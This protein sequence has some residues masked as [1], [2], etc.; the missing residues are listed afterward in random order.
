MTVSKTKC[1]MYHQCFA[2]CCLMFFLFFLLNKSAET[3]CCKPTRQ[4]K[5]QVL[6][7]QKIHVNLV[8]NAVG[9]NTNARTHTHAY[10]QNKNNS[11]ELLG[12]LCVYSLDSAQF[13]STR[14]VTLLKLYM[15]CQKQPIH[16]RS[17]WAYPRQGLACFEVVY[18]LRGATLNCPDL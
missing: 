6:C 3:T 17:Q 5:V 12:P 1:M 8:S 9:L 13:V 14:S 16:D 4:G 18:S 2:I 7:L 10:T 15:T 11:E